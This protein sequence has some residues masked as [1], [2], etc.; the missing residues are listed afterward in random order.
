MI[1]DH[2]H[3]AGAERGKPH[4]QK[5]PGIKKIII[6]TASKA[7]AKHSFQYFLVRQKTP[8][9]TINIAV[10]INNIVNGEIANGSKS[11]ILT[12][13]IRAPT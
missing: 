13:V 2:I 4:D 9:V 10:I 12:C 5:T 3:Q 11:K 8:P 1:K 7:E 6:K